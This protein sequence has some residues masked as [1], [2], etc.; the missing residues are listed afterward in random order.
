M[1]V[2][3]LTWMMHGVGEGVYK[4]ERERERERGGGGGGVVKGKV[5]LYYIGDS[6]KSKNKT[7]QTVCLT[8]FMRIDNSKLV[9]PSVSS[10]LREAVVII[11]LSPLQH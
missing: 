6:P 4:R 3:A 10:T 7:I 5:E 1:L 2:S 8:I 9:V 11:I